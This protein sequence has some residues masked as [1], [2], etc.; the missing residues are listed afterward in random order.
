MVDIN[1]IGRGGLVRVM[2]SCSVPVDWGPSGRDQCQCG[3]HVWTCT[4]QCPVR[5]NSFMQ[6]EGEGGMH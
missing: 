2:P 4:A 1:C 3:D 5:H 6:I